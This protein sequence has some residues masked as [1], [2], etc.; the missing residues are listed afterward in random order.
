MQSCSHLWCLLDDAAWEAAENNVGGDSED[1]VSSELVGIIGEGVATKVV[2]L[3]VHGASI[4]SVVVSVDQSHDEHDKVNVV[5]AAAV[6]ASKALS[7]LLSE[8]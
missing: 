8:C 6:E 5:G 2:H 7:Q 1:S 3:V 4:T